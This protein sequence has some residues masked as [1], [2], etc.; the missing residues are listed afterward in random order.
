[1]HEEVQHNSILSITQSHHAQDLLKN[2]LQNILTGIINSNLLFSENIEQL[3][4]L[5]QDIE[6]VSYLLSTAYTLYLHDVQYKLLFNSLYLRCKDD[7][8]ISKQIC[9]IIFKIEIVEYIDLTEELKYDPKYVLDSNFIDLVVNFISNSNLDLASMTLIKLRQLN[10]IETNDIIAI[11]EATPGN[12]KMNEFILWLKILIHPLLDENPFFIDLFVKWTSDRIFSLEKS[13]SW[14]KIGIKF[15][16]EILSVLQSAQTKFVTIRPTSMDGLDILKV[17]MNKILELKDKYRINILLGE[18]SS[19]SPMEVALIMLQRCYTEDLELFL[20]SY[21]CAYS[22]ECYLELDTILKSYIEHETS[23]NGGT[24][25]ETRLQIVLSA[26]HSSTTKL[27]CLLDVLRILNV[28]WSGAIRELAI[29]NA[30]IKENDFIICDT[31]LQ[32]IHEIK[33]ELNF[34]GL[35]VVL[36]K[37]NFPF[38]CTD[39]LLVL[40][41]VISSPTVDLNDLKIVMQLMSGY[42]NYG[43]VLY[44]ERCLKDSTVKKSLDYFK[45]LSKTEQKII[46]KSIMTKYELLINGSLSSPVIERCYLDFIKGTNLLDEVLLSKIEDL[47][48]LK[49]SY[50]IKISLN[51]MACERVRVDKVSKWFS[52]SGEWASTGRG[53]C[54]TQLARLP[55]TFLS[56]LVNL[57]SQSSAS[58]EVKSL[59]ESF[60]V[61]FTKGEVSY[62][63]VSAL[64]SNFKETNNSSTVWSCSLVLIDLINNC[65]EDYIHLLVSVLT[66]LNAIVNT[67]IRVKHLTI[68]WKFHYVFVPMSSISSADDLIMFYVNLLSQKQFDTTFISKIKYRNDFVPFRILSMCTYNNILFNINADNIFLE[69]KEKFAKKI[70]C[71]ILLSQ[72]CDEL[73]LCSCLLL[74]NSCIERSKPDWLLQSFEDYGENITNALSKYL[75]SP[76]MRH[77]LGLNNLIHVNTVTSAPQYILKSKYNLNFVDL[78]LHDIT[79]DTLD[80]K[81]VL[82]YVLQSYPD[83]TTQKL[84]DFCNTLHV[85]IDDGLSLQ[86]IS[87]LV[88][89]ELKYT[90]KTD[91]FNYKQVIYE[92]EENELFTNCSVVWD[93]I[94]NKKFVIDILKDFWK[95]GEV[96]LHGRLIAIN[97]YYYEIYL[98]IFKLISKHIVDS[99]SKNEYMLLHFLKDYTRLSSPKQ[100]EFEMFST[101]GMFPEIGHYRLPFQLFMREDMW[102]NLKS[103]ITLASYERWLPIATLLHLD[104]DLQIACDMLCSNALKQ[105]MT[106]RK[107][108]NEVKCSE[109]Q[110]D[111]WR[112]EATEEP[113]LRAAHC[114]VRHIANMEWAGACLFYVLQGCVRGADQVAAAQ[115]CYQFAQRW[116]SLQPANRAVR[117]MEKLHSS[118]STR[119]AL[120]KIDWAC[121]DLLKYSGE[122][123]QLVQA[124]YFHPDFVNKMTRYDVNNTVNE[125]ADKNNIN[126]SSVRIQIL[127][128][129]LEKTINEKR[130]GEKVG[131]ELEDVMRA[132]YVLKAT[133][134]KM[135]ALY[136]ARIALEDETDF[137]KTKKLRA[138]QCLISVVE[139]DT[140][141]KVTNQKRESLWCT[142]IELFFAIRLENVDMPWA[143]PT[144]TKDKVRTLEQV[145]SA[146]EN[147]V[148]ALHLAAELTV[149]YG[150]EENTRNLIPRLLA[151]TLYDVLSIILCKSFIY[152]NNFI[153]SAWK[154]VLVSPFSQGDYPITERQQQN[155]LKVINMMPLCQCLSDEILNSIWKHCIRMKCCTIACLILPFM[156]AAARQSLPEIKHF[157]KRKLIASLKNLQTETYLVNGAM[158]VLESLH[159]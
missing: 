99:I 46:L 21:L 5:F 156:S 34:A 117:Q 100:Y 141:L 25:D 111:P 146:S 31:D 12:I 88:G 73:L 62:D 148:E 53:A 134:P 130:N 6:D 107:R 22:A 39:Y 81:I 90:I 65:S 77:A 155:C 112:L 20:Q 85:D 86:L 149:R 67:S 109:K 76:I 127:E 66:F 108:N 98:C 49:N 133:C 7:N 82:Y 71:N 75:N 158:S 78:P 48:H 9:E 47:Y 121:E 151:N 56:N 54:V 114:C 38:N 61:L 138:L 115:L 125:I 15:L 69:A 128:N 131:L 58:V 36:K 59:V 94:K 135:G 35:K 91:E 150:N 159:S 44:I 27:K 4:K 45:S 26:F 3:T 118:L 79:E 70:I 57:L 16:G 95:K 113:L 144:F 119:H 139:P 52:A 1:M 104:S 74:L 80:A 68:A 19:L 33:M 84:L 28:P 14:P 13:T 103:E 2:N 43:S 83:T 157:N 51:D 89:W 137:N 63:V 102:S 122:P 110:S 64:M 30:T 101:K 29:T 23:D 17:H 60:I 24:T 55:E 92:K 140:A 126:I 97:P 152:P 123:F 124:I 142:L 129:I 116:A 40:H 42:S 11:L 136:L 50:D 105:T 145:C 93:S 96:L 41:K 147:G 154:A 10:K 106:A 153:Q 120:H 18:L 72:E 87:L 143:I 37:Y 132:K 32:L 8:L